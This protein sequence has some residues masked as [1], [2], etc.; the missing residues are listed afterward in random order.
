MSARATS[1]IDGLGLATGSGF[2][3]PKPTHEPCS[4]PA[5]LD[6]EEANGLAVLLEFV[7]DFAGQGQRLG[8]GQVDAAILK[9]AVIEHGDG[10]EAAGFGLARFAGPFENSNG[11]QFGRVLAGFGHLAGVLGQAAARRADG[12]RM[13]PAMIRPLP[14]KQ[15]AGHRCIATSLSHVDS[16]DEVALLPDRTIDIASAPA[17]A[18]DLGNNRT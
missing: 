5:L 12:Q 15:D 10:D 6:V 17:C 1:S 11:A 2:Q 13:I 8:T 7:F 16:D 9:L 14:E 18:A 4:W 3:A